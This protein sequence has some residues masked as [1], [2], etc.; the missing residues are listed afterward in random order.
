MQMVTA[1][2]SQQSPATTSIVLLKNL[3]MRRFAVALLLHSSL[4]V[5]KCQTGDPL[6]W[7]A[8]CGRQLLNVIMNYDWQRAR[9][10]MVVF[11]CNVHSS[12]GHASEICW[13]SL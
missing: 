12:K 8:G 11:P 7:C 1:T 3:V 13:Q 5:S 4:A 2:A 6:L 10:R 9:F